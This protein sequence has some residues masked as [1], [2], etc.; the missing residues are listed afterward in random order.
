MNHTS[1]KKSILYV[2]Y[3]SSII[4]GCHSSVPRCYL[5]ELA[6]FSRTGHSKWLSDHTQIRAFAFETSFF[7]RNR[8]FMALLIDIVRQIR[9][10]LLCVCLNS[11]ELW[12]NRWA[13]EMAVLSTC[14]NCVIF[15]FLFP[16]MRMRQESFLM[17]LFLLSLFLRHFRIYFT[18]LKYQCKRCQCRKFLS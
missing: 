10:C 1:W 9:M 14:R 4:L 16:L 12:R 13:A 17:P 18:Q 11:T 6:L 8:C 15:L 2:I 5:R 7:V 3:C